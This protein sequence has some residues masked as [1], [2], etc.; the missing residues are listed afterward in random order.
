M[1]LP[2]LN[3]RRRRR[4]QQRPH[5]S[6]YN[7]IST[8]Y[9]IKSNCHLSTAEPITANQEETVMGFCIIPTCKLRRIGWETAVAAHINMWQEPWLAM[10]D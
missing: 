3:T 4:R 5:L 6:L 8:Y 7:K 1:I 9:S 10:S 2:R